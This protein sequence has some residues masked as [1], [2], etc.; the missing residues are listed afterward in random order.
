MNTSRGN[1][2]ENGGG[3]GGGG[4]AFLADLPPKLCFHANNIASYASYLV[5]LPLRSAGTF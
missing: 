1:R 2:E 5:T 4:A 3:G